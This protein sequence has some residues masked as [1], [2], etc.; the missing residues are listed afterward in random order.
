MSFT[1]RTEDFIC[2]NCGITVHGDGFTNHCTRCLWSKHVDVDPGDRAHHCGGMMEPQ[3]LEGSS[4]D[5]TL[6]HR[7]V[8]CGAEKRNKVAANDDEKALVALASHP[9]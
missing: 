1:K 3:R 8:I 9:K 2:E 6:V 4:P 5:Y 7:C